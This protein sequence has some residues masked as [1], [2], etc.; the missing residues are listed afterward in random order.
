MN[1][2]LIRTDRRT[3][4]M[5]LTPEGEIIV[6]APKRC[7][8]KYIDGFVQ[9]HADWIRRNRNLLQERRQARDSVMLRDGEALQLCGM[10]LRI[11]IETHVLAS[12]RGDQL[13]LPAGKIDWI[14]EDLIDLMKTHGLPLLRE[15][16]NHWSRRMGISYDS[17]KTSTARHRWGSC[18]RHGVIRISVFLLLAPAEL[19][20]YVLVHELSHCRYLN[21]GAEF[22]A[23]VET[24]IPDWKE[25]RARLRTYQYDP[26]VQS[27]AVKEG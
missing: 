3:L 11:R 20:D 5:K 14:R 9:S 19:I 7:P 18:D 26:L 17:L 23:L 15:R 2:T 6:R 13:I 12:I 21:H 10:P 25:R 4:N 22:W 16:L 24:M 1:Y 8:V 27:L